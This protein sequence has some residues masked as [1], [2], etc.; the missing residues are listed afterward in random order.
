MNDQ[1]IRIKS[2]KLGVQIAIS[3]QNKG[4]SLEQLSKM[5]GIPLSFLDEIEKGN[6][7]P[8]MPQ[9]EAIASG[10]NIS[11]DELV[12]KTTTRTVTAIPDEAYLI[13]LNGLRNRFIGVSLRKA[14]IDQNI[15]LESLASQCDITIDE[16]SQFESGSTP[17]PYPILEILCVNLGMQPSSLSSKSTS[18]KP[19]IAQATVQNNLPEVLDKFVQNPANIPYL[20]VAKKLSEMD[21]AK[22][23]TI[24]EG[25]LEITY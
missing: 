2:K 19:Q 23:R 9:V 13:R 1:L 18:E 12:N 4:Y 24:A 11:F 16:L 17:I 20:E 14:R 3:R 5:T 22:L 15:S 7:C 21:A 10:L 6:Q 8:T 25:I